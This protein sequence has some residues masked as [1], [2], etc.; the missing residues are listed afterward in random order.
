MAN[1][2]RGLQQHLPWLQVK[3]AVHENKTKARR[4]GR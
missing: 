2:L 4:P 3:S 1:E